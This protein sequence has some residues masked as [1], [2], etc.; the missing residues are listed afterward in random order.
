MSI[1]LENIYR[2]YGD[3]IL[4]IEIEI[5]KGELVTLLGPSGCGKSTTLRII[6]GFEEPDRGKVLLEGR[7]L[8]PVPA[9]KRNIA[10]VF[11]D[12]ALFPHMNVRENIAYGPGIRKWPKSKIDEKVDHFIEIMH[13]KGLEKR[14]ID[15]LSGGEQQRTALA[16]ALVTE[17][18]LLLLDEPL[19]ALDARLRK[20]LRKE[21][22]RIQQELGITAIYVT[23]DQEEALAISD[24]IAVM[25]S[26]RCL[27]FDTPENIYRF[28]IHP[29][30]AGFI[31]NSNQVAVLSINREK[32]TVETP[33]GEFEVGF[34][35]DGPEMS[36]YFRPEKCIAY[37]EQSGT[38]TFSG[39]VTD[40]EYSGMTT[41][42]DIVS[43]GQ[44]VRVSVD[45]NTDYCKGDIIVVH[46]PR[47][48]C[49]V[50]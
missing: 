27:Q 12:Y 39:T 49:R 38:N 50:L 10:M 41:I 43:N 15:T 40:R 42:L 46:I 47:D 14:K 16:R 23:H 48:S 34:I 37:D 22:R 11:Q 26:G 29:F 21:I 1:K 13:L 8:C 25:N 31:G 5:N 18:D 44:V 28:P 30:S 20:N 45:E 6:A 32:G 7:D 35:G 3:F 24:R 4:D 19:S 36:L 9:E 33:V 17:P 2:D